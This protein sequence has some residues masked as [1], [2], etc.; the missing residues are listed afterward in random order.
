MNHN[1]ITD[2]CYTIRKGA[3]E[4]LSSSW[5]PAIIAGAIY[6]CVLFIPSVIAVQLFGK[7]F[8]TG[9]G[10]LYMLIVQGPFMLGYALYSLKLF[11]KQPAAPSDVFSGFDHFAKAF[12]L[13]LVMT[14]FIVLWTLLLVIPGII[15][16]YRYRL[17]YYVLLDNPNIGVMAAIAESKRLMSGNKGK[18]FILDLTFI[19]WGILAVLTFGLGFFV[20]VPYLAMTQVVFYERAN[21]NIVARADTITYGNKPE[22]KE[23]A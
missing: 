7:N 5:K 16:T 10:N 15:A 13:Q 9:V 18:F 12:M 2:S 21:G 22:I 17:A 20:L 11:R 8:G 4:A 14:I 23:E 1:L 6:I 3:R 19:G